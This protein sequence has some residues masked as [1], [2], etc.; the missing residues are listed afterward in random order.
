LA[1]PTKSL[2]SASRG[3]F[4]VSDGT[5]QFKFYWG[6]PGREYSQV[7]FTHEDPES[8]NLAHEELL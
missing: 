1:V 3:G 7:F 4:P 6:D 8:Q 5:A 2:L